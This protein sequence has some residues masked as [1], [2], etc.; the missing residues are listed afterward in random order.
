M[1]PRMDAFKA[2]AFQG[3]RQSNGVTSM[4]AAGVVQG[5][6]FR[7][8]DITIGMM[9]SPLA[10]HRAAYA[11]DRLVARPLAAGE[12]WVFPE[13]AEGTCVWNGCNDFVSI[14]LPKVGFETL[15][16]P[17][18]KI[19]QMNAGQLDPLTVALVMQIHQADSADTASALYRDTMASALTAHL[20][21]HFTRQ[22]VLTDS[23]LDD[24]RFKRAQ[25]YINEHLGSPISLDH[26]AAEAGMSAFHFARA[27]KAKTGLAPHQ[28][29]VAARIDRAKGLLSTSGISIGEIAAQVGWENPSKFAAQFKKHVGATPGQWRAQ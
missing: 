22:P 19:G 29:L 23:T 12:G 14:T 8:D 24:A 16:A 17:T 10:S 25:I 9:L 6:S 18:S 13:R 21:H 7:F 15:N 5:G 27:F 26:M 1:N 4:F 11:S 28:F 2:E 20:S 3:T